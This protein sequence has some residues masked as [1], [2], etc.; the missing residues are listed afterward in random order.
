MQVQIVENWADLEGDVRSVTHGSDV[1]GFDVVELDVQ[2]TR[3]VG[4]FP[5]FFA[6][7]VGEEVRVYVPHDIV[8]GLPLNTGV[9]VNCRVRKASPTR[10]FIDPRQVSVRAP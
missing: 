5:N 7:S 3:D 2:A 6:R 8:V 4:A 9:G 1:N 10:V